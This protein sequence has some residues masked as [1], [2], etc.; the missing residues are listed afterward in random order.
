MTILE[1]E[2]SNRPKC[3]AESRRSRIGRPNELVDVEVGFVPLGAATARQKRGVHNVHTL[4][5]G[6][7]RTGAGLRRIGYVFWSSP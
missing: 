6:L 7:G 4:P 5:F 2:T 1:A 3:V